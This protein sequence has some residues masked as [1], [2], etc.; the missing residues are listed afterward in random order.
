MPGSAGRAD[1]EV[2][3]KVYAFEPQAGTSPDLEIHHRQADRNAGS[4]VEDFVQEAV[5]RIVVVLA[6]PGEA[7]L[8]EEVCVQRRNP[9]VDIVFP[10]G[11]QPRG[12]R[13]AH[14]LEA[15]QVRFDD[16]ARDTR[17]RR[18]RAPQTRSPRP[19]PLSARS[20]SPAT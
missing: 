15:L 11:V 4:P 6:V 3:G 14:P 5:A 17:R 9:G 8:L 13:F 12:R 2:T 10:A 16:R 7:E 20:R 1:Q 18:V 19:G